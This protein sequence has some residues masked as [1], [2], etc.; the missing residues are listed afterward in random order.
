MIVYVSIGN[1][2][3]NLKQM[4]WGRFY[5]KIDLIIAGVRAAGGTIHGRWV[6]QSTDYWQN[7]CWCIEHEDE[8]LLEELKLALTARVNE[9]RQDSI[10]WAV[11]PYTEFLSPLKS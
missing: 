10:A 6:S 4:D 11:A 3:D 7:A 2:D 8:R 9:F 1:S 5:R